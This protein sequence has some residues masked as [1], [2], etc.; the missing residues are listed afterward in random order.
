MAADIVAATDALDWHG[1]LG[2]GHS[3]GGAALL[4]AEAARPGLLQAAYLYEPIVLDKGTTMSPKEN[5]M[6]GPAR[7]RRSSFP[8]KAE[9]LQ[10]Y[11]ARPPLN[12]LR[13][14]SLA[15]YVEHGF[16]E[17]ADGS[18]RLKCSG[19]DEA[20]T[21]N[22]AMTMDPDAVKGLAMP[23]TV[24]IGA[25]AGE[26]NPARMAPGVVARLKAARMLV[27]PHLGHFGPFQDPESIAADVVEL[28]RR[29]GLPGL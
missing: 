6:A 13:A 19:E 8:S 25:R 9:V 15:A 5:V 1:F 3:M 21:F 22:A 16:E 14:D 27:Y 4:L 20:R 7:R 18:V 12:V 17:L 28:A 24:A 2:V 11:A 29:A 26:P 10:R 23:T